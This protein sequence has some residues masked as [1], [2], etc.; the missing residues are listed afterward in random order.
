MHTK[1]LTLEDVDDS[2]KGKVY[3][4]DYSK[5]PVIEGVKIVKIE[6]Y[7]SGEGD[8]SEVIRLDEN[9]HLENI[10]SF[11]VAQVNRTRL[12]AGSIK[13]WHLHLKQDEIWYL[14]P[15]DELV[16]GLWDIRKSSQTRN[17][18]QKVVFGGGKSEF[19]LIPKGVAHGSANLSGREA[20]LFYFMNQRFDMNN[21]DELRIPWDA[22]GSDFW[23]PGR[24]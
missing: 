16:V 8:L 19:L 24:D 1:I 13:A 5:K 2:I 12:N 3:T 20:E 9:G 18:T 10:P 6:N 22:Q 23:T 11:R 21:P 14:I 7:L 4:Q 15:T 17:V